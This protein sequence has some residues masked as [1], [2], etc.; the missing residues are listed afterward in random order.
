MKL[1]EVFVAGVV[2]GLAVS[3]AY[4]L[5][6][7]ATIKVCRTYIEDRIYSSTRRFESP[8]D[9][10]GSIRKECQMNWPGQPAGSDD[11]TTRDA[12]ETPT[13]RE[14]PRLIIEALG[15]DLPIQY[16]CS[17]CLQVFPMTDGD[18]PKLAAAEMYRRFRE[19]VAQ[20]HA[21]PGE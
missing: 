18:S 7:K 17:W 5:S 14:K 3:W 16:Q 21:P 9:H 15:K 1:V 13:T 2:V 20:E 11:R 12:P 4:I 10:P 8:D 19:H 6:L